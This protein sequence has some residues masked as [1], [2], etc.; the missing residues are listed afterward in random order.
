MA[1]YQTLLVDNKDGIT[2]ITLNRPEKRNAMS[3]QLHR[4][5]YDCLT[6][7][8]YDKETRVIVITGAGESFCAGQD[9]KQYFIEM[10]SQP[11]RVRDEVRENRAS[12]GTKYCARCRSR[13][14]QKSTAGCLA[15]VL[16]WSRVAISRLRLTT[17]N[18]VCLKS[19]S[20]I[21]LAVK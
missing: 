9:L 13:S 12:G 15:A 17:C 1:T 14:L 4:E 5:M 7:L 19:I 11:D 10:D 18:S 3:P 16:P 6:D 21:F 20:A 2:T 8:K